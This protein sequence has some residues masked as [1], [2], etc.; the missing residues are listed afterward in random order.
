MI[1]IERMQI[2]ENMIGKRGQTRENMIGK[3]GQTRENMIDK[4]GQT[5]ENMIGIERTNTGEH[6]GDREDRHMGT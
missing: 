4:R 6:D 3:R 2:L 1:G 5:L